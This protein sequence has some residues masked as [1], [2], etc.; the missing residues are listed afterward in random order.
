MPLLSFRTKPP[1]QDSIPV[2]V[3]FSLYS[4]QGAMA[5]KVECK[6]GAALLVGP[7]F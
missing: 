4:S 6:W 3:P 5:Q 7:A 1:P 2:G